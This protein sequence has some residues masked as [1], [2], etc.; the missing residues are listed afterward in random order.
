MIVRKKVFEH[1]VF[2]QKLFEQKVFEQKVFEQKVF[3]QKVFEQKV[4]SNIVRRTDLPSCIKILPN[5]PSWFKPQLCHVMPSVVAKEY[6]SSWVQ[7]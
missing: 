2:E 3:E 4:F 6:F 1:K 5:D 7:N